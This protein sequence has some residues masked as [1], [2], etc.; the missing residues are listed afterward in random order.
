[1]AFPITVKIKNLRL[2]TIVGIFPQERESLQD[3][4]INATIQ[5]DAASA[6]HSD[7]IKDTLDYKTLTKNIID[8][9]EK[10]RW[11]LLEK[12]TRSV[13]DLILED[14]RVKKASVEIDKPMAL[15]F[16]DSVSCIAEA[17]RP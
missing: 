7:Q 6:L 5:F 15:R 17:Q 1:M 14:P 10:S 12:L 16:A 9:V 13:L 8:H 11:F 3:V 4:V 2:R